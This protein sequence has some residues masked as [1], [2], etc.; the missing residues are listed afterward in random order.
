MK[1]KEP[2]EAVAEAIAKFRDTSA[3]TP[4]EGDSRRRCDVC[5]TPLKL[6]HPLGFYYCP[7]RCERG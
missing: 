4:N 5:Q 2:A 3:P 7:L 1:P 6:S